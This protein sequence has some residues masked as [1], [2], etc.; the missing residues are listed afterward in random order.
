MFATIP[1]EPRRH[2]FAN[3]P[4]GTAVDVTLLQGGTRTV[5]VDN[6]EVIS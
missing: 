1:R 4:Q 3:N 6:L 2:P 5:P